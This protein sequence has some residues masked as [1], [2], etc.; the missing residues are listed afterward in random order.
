M[1]LGRVDFGVLDRAA[2][3]YHII[4]ETYRWPLANALQRIPNSFDPQ[5]HFSILTLGS[6]A[7]CR[8]PGESRFPGVREKAEIHLPHYFRDLP[9]ATGECAARNSE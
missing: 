8:G 5:F 9:V 6:I 1:G 3:I 7:S 4:L 2:Y